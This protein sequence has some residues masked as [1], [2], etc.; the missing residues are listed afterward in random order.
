MGIAA[1]ELGTARRSNLQGP[2]AVA[3]CGLF[4]LLVSGHFFGELPLRYALPLGL[5]PLAGWIVE[6]G[7]MHRFSATS[8]GWLRVALAA[9]I[10]GC[11]TLLAAR[12][13]AASSSG[14]AGGAAGADDYL[15][16]GS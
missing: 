6:F 2:L 12:Q 15:N 1:V 4:S 13:F 9:G 11:V 5:A 10:V 3:T 7:P 16:Y 14:T 8:R